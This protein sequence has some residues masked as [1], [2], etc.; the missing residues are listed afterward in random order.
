MT[1]VSGFQETIRQLKD[2]AELKFVGALY[3]DPSLLYDYKI[4]RNLFSNTAWRFYYSLIR[5]LNKTK[6]IGTIE[7]I[8]IDMYMDEHGEKMKAI[9]NR[10][11]GWGTIVKLKKIGNI[12]NIETSFNDVNRFTVIQRMVSMHYPVEENWEELKVKTVDEL[13][14][15]T[16]Q[17]Q[18]NIFND[19]NSGDDQAIDLTKGVRGTVEAS[20]K[21]ALIGLP[22]HSS[23]L[24]SVVHGNAIGHITMLAA[25]SGAGKSF[26]TVGLI[27]PTII[28]LKQ[29]I[30]IMVNEEG[31]EKW[32]QELVTWVANNII[33]SGKYTEYEEYKGKFFEKSRFYEGNFTKEEDEV[34]ELAI[35]WMEDNIDEGLLNFVNFD[36]YAAHKAIKKIRQF[37]T[38][39][40][41][42][43][44]I[45]DTMKVDN[46]I[47]SDSRT[48]NFWLQLQQNMVKIYNTIK[49]N[50][51]N[52]HLWVTYQ[53]S[54]SQR[55]SYLDQT[56]LGMSKNVADV[57]STLMLARNLT[58]K[59]KRAEGG[60]VVKRGNKQVTLNENYEYMVVFLDKNRRG[61]T[62]S[63]VVLRV[64]KGKNIIRDVGFTRIDA[65][66]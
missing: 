48:D 37:A 41:V 34:L 35:Q 53:M 49:D 55:M 10:H 46:D 38:T 54:K 64:D 65:D 56:S 51:L 6:K 32:Q 50:G 22:L 58:E 52:V 28:K 45:I 66:F 30:L 8:E 3:N 62:H 33:T 31:E 59:E 26:L 47:T 17:L 18:A 27:I 63:Q 25:S 1:D 60:L 11:G 2:N 40:G 9:Y 19:I 14:S 57:V 5:D 42:K 15:F 13:E 20:R 24:N 29:P 43:Y 7:Q 23:L 12:D 16:Q 39:K 36:T 61:A 44:F 4:A 21:G